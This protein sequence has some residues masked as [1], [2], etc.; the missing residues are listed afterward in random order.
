MFSD[1]TIWK[2]DI[3][4]LNEIPHEM[5]TASESGIN[6]LTHIT[7]NATLSLTQMNWRIIQKE[8]ERAKELI[9]TN[10]RQTFQEINPFQLYE[11]FILVSVQTKDQDIQELLGRRIKRLIKYLHNNKEITLAQ[12][13]PHTQVEWKQYEKTIIIG[14]DLMEMPKIL[15]IFRKI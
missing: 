14:V 11:S 3:C 4:I 10:W 1:P 5:T 12:H 9:H 7:Q 13:F 8:L 6:I 15:R 2:S